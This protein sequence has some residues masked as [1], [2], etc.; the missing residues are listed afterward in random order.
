MNLDSVEQR[1]KLIDELIDKSF[2]YQEILSEYEDDFDWGGV[3]VAWD[4]L[5]IIERLVS[6]EEIFL[7]TYK[8]LVDTPHSDDDEKTRLLEIFSEEGVKVFVGELFLDRLKY[9]LNTLN[10]WGFRTQDGKEFLEYMRAN[11]EALIDKY[12]NYDP[13][14]QEVESAELD[15]CLDRIRLLTDLFD[16]AQKLDDDFKKNSE[17]VSFGDVLGLTVM[18]EKLT[19]L[20]ELLYTEKI[21]EHALEGRRLFVKMVLVQRLKSMID[22]AENKFNDERLMDFQKNFR[23]VMKDLLAFYVKT[24]DL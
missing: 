9:L 22:F 7:K 18:I 17:Q 8:K 21:F 14:A 4:D 10:T 12:T 24:Y 16:R 13:A 19:A 3:K 20:R 1:H 11:L 6:A 5:I 15:T 23:D 2:E